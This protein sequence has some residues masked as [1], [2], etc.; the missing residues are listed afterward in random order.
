MVTCSR[1][2]CKL[3]T[4]QAKARH[5]RALFIS[6]SGTAP[7]QLTLRNYLRVPFVAAIVVAFSRT[8]QNEKRSRCNKV[9]H[10]RATSTVLTRRGRPIQAPP[11]PPPCHRC[12]RPGLP[13]YGN[14]S[15]LPVQGNEEYPKGY[16]TQSAKAHP[17]PVKMIV[18]SDDVPV[19][20]AKNAITTSAEPP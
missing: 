14:R 18:T 5:P 12:R 4:V 19:S 16:A 10:V 2:R 17:R 6:R 1:E 11:E 3:C 13:Y 7:A 15:S 20:T 9:C 8:R